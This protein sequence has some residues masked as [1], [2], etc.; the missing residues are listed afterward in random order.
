MEDPEEDPP[1]GDELVEGPLERVPAAPAPADR[2]RHRADGGGLHFLHLAGGFLDLHLPFLVLGT[3]TEDQSGEKKNQFPP[4]AWLVPKSI[5]PKNTQ[6]I[7]KKTHG[8]GGNSEVKNR[9]GAAAFR[10]A[11]TH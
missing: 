7:E 10:V 8:N 6:G 5:L 1:F 9:T 3:V 2:H 11:G 4:P